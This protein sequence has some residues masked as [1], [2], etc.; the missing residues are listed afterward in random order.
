[1]LPLRLH[2]GAPPGEQ[3]PHFL[4]KPLLGKKARDLPVDLAEFL[5]GNG[6]AVENHV[7]RTQTARGAGRLQRQAERLLRFRRKGIDEGVAPPVP[8][9]P[10]TDGDHIVEADDTHTLAP[11]EWPQKIGRLAV[12]VCADLDDAQVKTLCRINDRCSAAA[13]RAEQCRRKTGFLFSR[14]YKHLRSYRSEFPL[15]ADPG[16]II[17]IIRLI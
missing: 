14:A 7:P 13:R 15:R 1:M 5:A 17:R 10:P 12:K 8:F 6:T 9:L 2:Q 11:K 16:R 4:R 3:F